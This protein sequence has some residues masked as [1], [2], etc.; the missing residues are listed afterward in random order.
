MKNKMA[1]GGYAEGGEMDSPTIMRIMAK[2][3]K[4]SEGGMVANGGDADLD[5]LADG[6]SAN[7]DDLSL[8]DDLESSYTG[9]NSGD[10]IGNTREEMDRKDSIARIMRQRAMRK[11][12]N[13]KPA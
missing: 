1:C 7:F 12:T 5:M 9:A 4:M 10:E 2:R 8:R 13:P 3:K 6:D 11:N